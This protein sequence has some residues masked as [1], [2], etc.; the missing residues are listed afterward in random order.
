MFK[1]DPKKCVHYLPNRVNTPWSV[2][3][4]KPDLDEQEQTSYTVFLEPECT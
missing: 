3:D 2:K 1:S 4:I